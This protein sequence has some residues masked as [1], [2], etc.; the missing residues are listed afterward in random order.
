MATMSLAKMSRARMLSGMLNAHNAA[1]LKCRLVRIP[2]IYV[3]M[4]PVMEYLPTNL[5]QSLPVRSHPRWL[6]TGNASFWLTEMRG[7]ALS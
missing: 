6:L 7:K 5:E 2:S 1:K 3:R 4:S